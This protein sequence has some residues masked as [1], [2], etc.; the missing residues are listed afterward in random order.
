MRQSLIEAV[1]SRS[2]TTRVFLGAGLEGLGRTAGPGSYI[3]LDSAVAGL[4]ADRLGR[5]M[6]G[7]AA[8]ASVIEADE[9]AKTMRTVKGL[10]A[11]FAAAGLGRSGC[12]VAAGGGMVCDTAAFAASIWMRGVR[13]VLVPTTL[14]AQ[15]DACLGGKTGVNLGRAKNQAGTFHPASA[16]FVDPAFLETL[17]R[18]EIRCGLGEILKTAV[19]S[20]D[21]KLRAMLERMPRTSASMRD[22]AS[23][24]VRRCLEA[25][26]AIV[27]RDPFDEGERVLLN[28]G[29]TLGHA[30]ESA[31]GFDLA[32]GEAVALGCLASAAMARRAGAAGGLEEEMRELCRATGLRDRLDR[33]DLR[34]VRRYLER[35][36][37]TSSGG[38][39]WVFPYG[40]GDCRPTL[41]EA[42][43]ET[44]LLAAGLEAVTS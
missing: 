11:D 12:V 29:H 26:A 35:D 40:W 3:V 33:I 23:G 39:T 2:S 16:V 28:L 30:L 36:K 24:A 19:V 25:K 31:T 5:E 6:G 20:G 42:R 43:E 34:S 44:A 27:S 10:L 38:R 15:V 7:L 9:R 13:L 1:F 21:R 14:L 18:R 41:L 4:H 37:K 17:P 22:W 8:G 32:H